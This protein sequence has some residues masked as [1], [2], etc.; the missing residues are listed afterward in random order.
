MDVVK[1]KSALLRGVHSVPI[2]VEVAITKGMPSMHI[3]GMVDASVLEARERCRCAIKAS[4]FSWPNERILV[5]LSPNNIRK[6]GSC[7][8]LAIAAGILYATGQIPFEHAEKLHVGELSLDGSV[9][10]VRGSE[11]FA[12]LANELGCGCVLPYGSDVLGDNDCHYISNLNNLRD[13][14]LLR[15]SDAC[16]QTVND[17]KTDYSD[18]SGYAAEKRACQIA[19]AGRFNMLFVAPNNASAICNMLACRIPSILPDL[20]DAGR[21]EVSRIKSACGMPV[22]TGI[23]RPFRSPHHSITAAG[24][25]GGGLPVL[26]GEVSLAHEGVLFLEDSQQWCASTLQQ[27]RIPLKEKVVNVVRADGVYPMPA[28]FML[29]ASAKPCPCG[30][31]GDVVHE[32]TCSASAVK[33]YQNRLGGSISDFVDMT[34]NISGGSDSVV[35]ASSDQLK[36]GVLLAWERRAWRDLHYG[37][38]AGIVQKCNL[39]A[40]CEKFLEDYA[41]QFV[42][43][44][45]SVASVLRVSRAIADIEGCDFVSVDHIAEALSFRR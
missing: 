1:I 15:K 8:D 4:G 32:C 30:F 45:I 3:V 16:A 33:R 27:L 10:P 20:S 39:S 35:T 31:Y 28:N 2:D 6:S 40:S 42:L 43:S 34:V 5:N 25:L 44:G 17:D 18:I 24:L 37:E 38:S 29:V 7:F 41:R 36:S 13:G 12:H 19:A 21:S 14:N 26:P 9:L 22:D 23:R 11:C